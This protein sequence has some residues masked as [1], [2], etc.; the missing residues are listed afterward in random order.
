MSEASEGGA[1]T[2]LQRAMDGVGAWRAE[3]EALIDH[4]LEEIDREEARIREAIE[5][6]RGELLALDGL[7]AQVRAEAEGLDQA[8]DERA[9]QALLEG[10]AAERD[11]LAGRSVALS[12]ARE[13]AQEAL[14]A[15]L[16]DPEI[17]GFVAEYERYSELEGT[18]DALPESYRQAIQAHHETVKRRLEP[19]FARAE[20]A[21][22]TL[23]AEVLPLSVVACLEDVEGEDR[24]ESLTL[25]L[26][27]DAAVYAGWAE[28]PEDLPARL[29]YRTVALAARLARTLG[30]ADAPLTWRAHEGFVSV[31]LWLGDHELSGDV[32]AAAEAEAEATY[33]AADQL[34]AARVRPALHWVPPEI[35]DPPEEE[36][37]G[38][39]VRIATVV[40]E[41][42]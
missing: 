33:G 34:A 37:T 29:G 13:A 17:A 38:V 5:Q 20:A 10:L 12:S 6:L 27:V 11:A 21:D 41:G 26:P 16:E 18:L 35:L 42:V 25:V 19:F 28:R 14:S 39:R 4:R 36:E 15:E 8:R 2:A 23:D 30:A 24:P 1:A 32:R 3:V 40:G 9:H 7:R 22:V 31:H